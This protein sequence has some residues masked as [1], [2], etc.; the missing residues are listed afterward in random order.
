MIL[1]IFLYVLLILGLAFFVKKRTLNVLEILSIWMLVWIIIHSA[2]S[3]IVENLQ[4]LSV[5]KDLSLFLTH[6]IKR[7]FLYP[8]LIIWSFDLMR[9][10]KSKLMIFIH[11]F[12]T[13]IVLILTEYITIW[14]GVM[15]NKHWNV[16]YSFIE[17]SV[18]LLITYFFWIWF[19]KQLKKGI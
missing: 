13:V 6:V 10:Y 12:S 8:L 5:S 7:L 2:S 15:Q 11:L 17:W 19:R 3:I 9:N 16:L 1:S 14:V 4:Y 18:C